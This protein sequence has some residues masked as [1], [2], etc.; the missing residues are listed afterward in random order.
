M[1]TPLAARYNRTLLAEQP[2]M[3]DLR[4]LVEPYQAMM[5]AQ[6]QAIL[7]RSEQSRLYPWL[8]TQIQPDHRAG[9]WLQRSGRR[10]RFGQRLG[11]RAW[12]GG[13]GELRPL[14]G[15]LCRRCRGGCPAAAHPAPGGGALQ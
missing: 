13:H 14:A 9:L 11:A 8:D 2:S 7:A 12:V 1:L 15:A 6:F 5:I 4:T 10:P 3:D